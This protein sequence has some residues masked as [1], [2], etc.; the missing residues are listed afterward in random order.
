MGYTIT[1]KDL[2]VSYR[3][4]YS[5]CL[6]TKQ[7]VLARVTDRSLRIATKFMV[8]WSLGPGLSPPL[9]D[10][11]PIHDFS[12][13]K[14]P[15]VSSGLSSPNFILSASNPIRWICFMLT[16]SLWPEVCHMP[17]PNHSL[18]PE[19]ELPDLNLQAHAW[20]QVKLLHSKHIRS[21]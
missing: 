17:I 4:P 15:V 11:A 1:I 5:D 21:F 9:G 20:C 16:N 14:L 13:L 18:W 12:V 3:K 2:F 19:A 7:D 10:S 6:P 8:W